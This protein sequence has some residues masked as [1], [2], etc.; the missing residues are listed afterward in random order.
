[1]RLR[2]I[3]SRLAL[4][5][6]VVIALITGVG[7]YGAFFARRVADQVESV[8]R[9]SEERSDRISNLRE[10]ARDLHVTYAS[11]A[12]AAFS[13]DL[14]KTR[15]QEKRFIDIM[16]ELGDSVAPQTR[17]EIEAELAN[18][19]STGRQWVLRAVE[20]KQENSMQLGGD[21]SPA[22][23]SIRFSAATD[24]LE[25]RLDA[26]VIAERGATRAHLDELSSTLGYGNELFLVG[27]LICLMVG[28]GF[29]YWL[30]KSFVTP[31]AELTR[32]AHRIATEGDLTQPID[33]SRTDEFGR[34]AGAL[35]ELVRRLREIPIGLRE[36]VETLQY[37][38]NDMDHAFTDQQGTFSRQ[39]AAIQ[40]TQVTL[41]EIK[42]TSQLA[43][44]KATAVMSRSERANEVSRSGELALQR[45][46]D[47]LSMIR[48]G[49]DDIASRIV[50]LK[51]KTTQISGITATV[52]DIAD[53]SSMLALNAAIEAVRSGEHGRGFS[54]VAREIRSLADQSIDSTRQVGE[55]L[56]DIG[57]AIGQAVTITESGEK[58]IESGMDQV[59]AS[60]NH[61]RELAQIVRESSATVRQIA[62][63][64]SQ[65]NDGIAQLFLAVTDVSK[66]ME[67]ARDR[68]DTT[69]AARSQMKDASDRVAKVISSFR[70]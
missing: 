28:G 60:S 62:A 18:V 49:F 19:T 3:G 5:F 41:Q 6:G 1:M 64:V 43:A 42:Q 45:S 40:Q 24:K 21:G 11:L 56:D 15:A 14:S 57:R 50:L 70:L 39:A 66:M 8:V 13:S 12:A 30:K 2:G 46:V 17:R 26:A 16:G 36:S 10:T 53:Q 38:V 44:E 59:K 68:L 34:L 52:K 55:A 63:A 47:G 25:K 48:T 67:A 58:K 29:A 31:V 51:E 20:A 22:D 23:L 61:M 69:S 9:A 54:V 65:Q 32:V 37:A 7:M 4:A 35:A 27:V 33:T